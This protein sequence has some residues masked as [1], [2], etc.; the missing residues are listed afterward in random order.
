MRHNKSHFL[1]FTCTLMVGIIVNVMFT[2][3]IQAQT[4]QSLQQFDHARSIFQTP[5]SNS[6]AESPD[7]PSMTAQ[8]ELKLY[9][10]DVD[11]H[12][13]KTQ[14]NDGSS[15]QPIWYNGSQTWKNY[16]LKANDIPL[17]GNWY[18]YRLNLASMGST[19]FNLEILIG[20]QVV[21]SK[22]IWVSVSS[23]AYRSG[24]IYGIKPDAKANDEV[25]LRITILSGD[26]GR[27]YWGSWIDSYI[28]LFESD[29]DTFFPVKYTYNPP[30]IDGQLDALWDEAKNM[31]ISNTCPE[32]GTPPDNQ[33]DL[34]SSLRMMWDEDNIYLFYHTQ[35]DK[36]ST[37]TNTDYWQFDGF[38]LY[39]DA[40]NSKGANAPY[41]GVDDIQMRFNYNFDSW[42]DINDGNLGYGFEFGAEWDFD[43]SGIVLQKQ[44]I[45]GGWDME[46]AIPMQDLKIDPQVDN[47]FGFEVQTNDNDNDYGM[48]DHLIKWWGDDD[49]SWRDASLFGE[50]KLLDSGPIVTIPNKSAGPG[51]VVDVPVMIEDATGKGI[52]SV[53][54]T[55]QT[56]ANILTPISAST[57]GSIAESWG[58]PT[59]GINNGQIIIGMSGTTP[60][61]GSGALVFIKYQV[62]PSA[63]NGDTAPLHIANVLLNEGEPHATPV[64]GLFTAEGISISGNIKYH[65]NKLPVNEVI[66]SLTGNANLTS[67]TGVD[68]NYEF[69]D[70]LWGNY[71]VKP[72][73]EDVPE[74]AISPYDA[75]LVLQ[76]Y[77]G[78]ADF[79]PYQKIAGDVS[80][81][82][83][84]TPY[85]ASYILQYWVGL[86]PDFE[87]MGESSYFWTFV[88]ESYNINDTNWANAPHQ[89]TYKPLQSSKDKQDFVGIIY[90]DPSGN[91]SP[92]SLTASSLNAASNSITLSLGD[93]CWKQEKLFSVPVVVDNSNGFISA[94]MTVKYDS[95]SLKVVNVSTTELTSD[96]SLAHNKDGDKVKIA[97]AA[98][99]PLDRSGAIVN[100]TFEVLKNSINIDDPLSI[101]DAC[102][103]DG[104]HNVFI[105]ESFLKLQTSLPAKFK[106]SQNYPNPFNPRTTIKYQL[107]EKSKVTLKIFNL[108]GQEVS[109]LV[110]EDKEAGYHEILW[111]GKDFNGKRVSSGVYIYRIQT[112]NLVQS[113]KMV[114][115]K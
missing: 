89:K 12:L 15:Y 16:F 53:G 34:S 52:Y 21:A 45:P 44:D 100:I 78:V 28:K 42:Q 32:S 81:N 27:V 72:D 65:F 109:T 46:V 90:G 73:K 112:A 94:G 49:F 25:E 58:N 108:F 113:K 17:L 47:V 1:F 76:N 95:K 2:R 83:E 60:L 77:V 4:L 11:G 79:T 36:I 14:Q 38:E 51:S 75:S 59:V 35:D 18:Y 102:V 98:S 106:L 30:N 50:A 107:P 85:D 69:S 8:Q 37:N 3:V 71:T 39:W 24:F 61:N 86:V 66:V 99:K 10:R 67:T 105:R 82:G 22:T 62:N 5:K 48:R 29:K 103:N 40:D 101:Q 97:L 31:P 115:T 84:L 43:A 41:D 20:G 26:G 57:A 92:S 33:A 87:V 23:F 9:L 70:L 110:N 93:I 64:D 68:G 104:S 80:G 56:D 13:G 74:N 111:D 7:D 96:Y 54:L 6:T 55:V 91:W 19:H 88:P 63:S 114:I